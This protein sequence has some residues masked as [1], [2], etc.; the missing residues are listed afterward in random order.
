[1]QGGRTRGSPPVEAFVKRWTSRLSGSRN[2]IAGLEGVSEE[3]SSLLLLLPAGDSLF[4]LLILPLHQLLCC[5]Q[6]MFPPFHH[7]YPPE[8]FKILLPCFSVL[9]SSV[10]GWLAAEV[11]I[12]AVVVA[13]RSADSSI[14]ISLRIRISVS[15]SCRYIRRNLDGLGIHVSLPIFERQR[16]GSSALSSTH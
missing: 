6:L 16:C 4:T 2:A 3:D 1:M 8:R 5:G 14:C 12:A 10:L 9:A 7:L 11:F 13:F 15:V